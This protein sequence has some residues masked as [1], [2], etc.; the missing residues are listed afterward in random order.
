MFSGPAGN[1]IG[2]RA[3]EV[4]PREVADVVGPFATCRGV[5]VL[6]G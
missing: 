6:S 2:P 3:L 5:V 1:R 4:V